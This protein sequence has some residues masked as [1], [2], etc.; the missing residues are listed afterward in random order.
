MPCQTEKRPVMKAFSIEKRKLYLYMVK[1]KSWYCPHCGHIN[2]LQWVQ[3]ISQGIDQYQADGIDDW[4]FCTITSSGKLKNRDQCLWVEPK[5]WKKLFSRIHYHHGKVR[6][7]YI[8][9]LHKK[10]KVHWHLLMS[11]AIPVKWWK[12]HAPRCGFGY[13]VDSEPVRDGRNSVL[14]VSK[15]LSKSL[16]ISQWPRNLRRI[17]TN[18]QWPVI[19]DTETYDRLQLPWVYYRQSSV[20]ELEFLRQET[21]DQ[22]GIETILL[23]NEI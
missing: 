12:Y 3:K 18:Q 1:C 23:S 21:E 9:E 17:R 10:G 8:P 19:P 4:M 11:G 2:K 5:A 22:S 20:E 13:M 7:V 16:A 14:Y 15:E 6:Y